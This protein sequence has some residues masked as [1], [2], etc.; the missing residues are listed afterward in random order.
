[1]PAE[2]RGVIDDLA[3]ASREVAPWRAMQNLRERLGTLAGSLD[4][5][6]KA[7]AGQLRQSLDET[8]ERAALPYEPRS[9][10]RGLDDIEG[11]Y[12]AEGAGQSPDIA[13]RLEMSRDELSA[14]ADGQ[15]APSGQTALQFIIRNGGIRNE[16]GEIANMLGGITRTRPGLLNN[17]GGMT[18]DQVGERLRCSRC[19]G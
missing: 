4:G 3:T 1:M 5:R 8:A 19:H 2:L 9:L 13:R 14:R 6:V 7:V 18:L 11:Q 10:P 15:A 12:A 16:G 17:R